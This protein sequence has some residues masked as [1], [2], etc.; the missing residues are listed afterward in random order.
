MNNQYQIETIGYVEATKLEFLIHVFDQYR[1]GLKNIQGFS[2]LQVVWWAHLMDDKEYRNKTIIKKLFKNVPDEMGVFATR[3][4]TRP[5][6]IMIS[7]VKVK[8]I[9][10][11][12]GIIHTPFIDAEQKTPIIDIK[13][14]FPMERV[15]NCEVPEFFKNWPKWSEDAA[16]YDWKKEI[17][18]KT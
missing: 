6:P 11:E 17:N 15:K 18:F 14:Y 16:T 2:H 4:P 1:S 10:F 8:K 13:P 12:K 3:A 9:D 5:N 7:T